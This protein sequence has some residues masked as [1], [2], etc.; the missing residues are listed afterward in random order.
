[1]MDL[2]QRGDPI[3]SAHLNILKLKTMKSF[4]FGIL[5]RFNRYCKFSIM[6]VSGNTTI[7]ETVKLFCSKYIYKKA[8]GCSSKYHGRYDF[9]VFRAQCKDI[10]VPNRCEREIITSIVTDINYSSP[11]IFIL[12]RSFQRTYLHKCQI[13][14]CRPFFLVLMVYWMRKAKTYVRDKLCTYETSD[15]K[16]QRNISMCQTTM[17]VQYKLLNK[18]FFITEKLS[19][20]KPSQTSNAKSLTSQQTTLRP[21]STDIHNFM[22]N[23]LWRHI[24]QIPHF[25]RSEYFRISGDRYGHDRCLHFF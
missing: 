3:H 24:N 17:Y 12:T 25:P 16:D 5:N 23:E 1:M 6:K 15:T 21:A 4:F 10:R 13:G 14:V 19:G 20:D 11:I 22:N 7:L 9:S 18:F 8:C 2:S